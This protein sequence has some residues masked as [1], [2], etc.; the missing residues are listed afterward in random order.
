MGQKLSVK[1]NASISM[2]ATCE[3]MQFT[4]TRRETQAPTSRAQFK[5]GSPRSRYHNRQTHATVHSR[6]SYSTDSRSS[7]ASE[8]GQDD[9]MTAV[10]VRGICVMLLM[11]T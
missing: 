3:F 5:N 11:L 6:S 1:Y 4:I 7:R 2:N 10:A 9:T 8:D